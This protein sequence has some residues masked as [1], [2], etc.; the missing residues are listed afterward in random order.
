MRR[1]W[2]SCYLRDKILAL[3]VNRPTRIKD[4]EFELPMLQADDFELEV[5]ATRLPLLDHDHIGP[6]SSSQQIESAELLVEKTKLFVLINRVLQRQQRTS[7]ETYSGTE[8]TPEHP[9]SVEAIED[10]LK[11]WLA[12][13]PPS[14]RWSAPLHELPPDNMTTSIHVRRNLLHMSYHTAMYSLHRPRFLPSSP[15]QAPSEHIPPEARARSR[16][17]VLDSVNK[18]TH[19][20]AELHQHKLDGNLPLAAITVLYPAIC[21][22]LLNMKSR[23]DHVR[24]AAIHRFRVCMRI[25]EKLRELYASADATIGYLEIV[26]RSAFVAGAPW[27]SSSAEGVFQLNRQDR[28]D[29]SA[30]LGY[31]LSPDAELDDAV[32]DVPGIQQILGDEESPVDVDMD[33]GSIFKE[34]CPGSPLGS[35]EA[36]LDLDFGA[37]GDD[38]EQLD[39]EWPDLEGQL[40]PPASDTAVATS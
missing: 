4:E 34:V 26:L 19:L 13:L 12:N 40:T 3:G 8:E 10:A 39:I 27:A 32:P 35:L 30:V 29:I 24:E 22:H 25:M 28:S 6:Y 33:L 9:D 15:H 11:L 23:N 2:W 7:F 17:V 18:I 16:A 36:L 20:A 14:C 38:L 31:G 37:N 1:V 21:M 5:L